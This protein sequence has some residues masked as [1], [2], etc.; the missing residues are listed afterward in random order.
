MPAKRLKI[1]DITC[2]F[3]LRKSALFAGERVR[4]TL[5]TP[6]LVWKRALRQSM[7]KAS[8]KQRNKNKR[9]EKPE[10][11][12]KRAQSRKLRERAECKSRTP[13]E[14]RK[15]AISRRFQRTESF[16]KARANLSHQQTAD[17]KIQKFAKHWKFARP[18]IAKSNC[19]AS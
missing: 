9:C 5:L 16:F 17:T 10:N 11:G 12:R 4:H 2:I 1:L 7:R 6:F 15:P 13:A 19:K 8:T 14:V 18:K 3:E